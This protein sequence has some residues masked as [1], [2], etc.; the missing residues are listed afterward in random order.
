MGTLWC[1]ALSHVECDKLERIGARAFNCCTSLRSINLPSARIV[2]RCAFSVLQTALKGAKF[3][4]KLERIEGRVFCGCPSL[5]RITIPLKNGVITDDDVFME[6]RVFKIIALIERTLLHE[7]IAALHLE[8]WRN[9]L[10]VEIDSI[11]HL[12][13]VDAGRSDDDDEDERRRPRRYERGLDRFF[14]KLFT[15]KLNINA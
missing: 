11:N 2:E 13:T 4:S 5:E 10:S 9:D 3:G 12:P 6:C 8:D 14:V 7:T 1:F 15:T